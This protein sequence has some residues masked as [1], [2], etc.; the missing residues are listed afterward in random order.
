MGR[1]D[2]TVS[3]TGLAAPAK[4]SGSNRL[5]QS[6]RAA[7]RAITYVGR[8]PIAHANFITTTLAPMGEP[9]IE[10]SENDAG[11]AARDLDGRMGKREKKS[12]S[13]RKG[14]KI[15]AFASPGPPLRPPSLSLFRSFSLSEEATKA[16]Y[17][18]GQPCVRAPRRGAARLVK[19][20]AHLEPVADGGSTGGGDAAGRL[21]VGK[22]AGAHAL[23]SPLE[24]VTV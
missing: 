22:E 9:A 18:V 20:R 17:F 15:G 2:G 12:R 16:A 24:V 1:G 11:L 21:S 23:S 4:A 19:W 5:V 8:G 6:R 7:L 13:R 14:K 10:K 3:G